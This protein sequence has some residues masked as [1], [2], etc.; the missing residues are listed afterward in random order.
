MFFNSVTFEGMIGQAFVAGD[1]Q[2]FGPLI[3]GNNDGTNHG[4]PDVGLLERDCYASI[5]F[6]AT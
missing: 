4:C 2:A 6:S 3:T 5:Y 1:W